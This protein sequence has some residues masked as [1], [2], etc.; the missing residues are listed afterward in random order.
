MQFKTN[1]NHDVLHKIETGDERPT[2]CK[3]RPLLASSE[4]S[5]E[6]HK[7]WLQMQKMGVIE[8]VDPSKLTEW[9]SPLHLARKPQGR[10]WRPCGDFRGLNSKTK[11]DCYPLPIL[12]SFT[13]RLRSA[14]VFS[15]IDLK[16]AFH[17]LPIH[18]DSIDK[19]T[20]LSPWGGAFVFKRLPFGLA[21]GPS[22]YQKFMDKC[23]SGIDNLFTYMDDILVFTETLDQ[24]MSVL[25]ELFKRLEEFGLSLALDKCQFGRKSVDY[26]GYS[27]SSAGI[28]PLS[29]KIQAIVSIPEPT[30]QKELLAFLGGLNYFRSSLQG[31]VKNNKF[32]K[33]A[34]LLQPLYAVATTKLQSKSK[35][36]EVWKHSPHLKSAFQD[37]K[38][39]LINAAELTHP[40]PN[41]P[42]ALVTD[43]SQTSVGA[44]L[45][46][47]STNGVWAPLG[48]F[49]RHLPIDKTKWATYRLE[50]LAVQ[51]ALRHF[52]NEIYGRHLSVWTD[53]KPLEMAFKGQG[54]QL[55]DPVAQRAL[56]EIG[57]FTRDIR[58][59]AGRDNE[60]SDY[61]SRIPLANVTKA[62]IDV[63]KKGTAY[64]D[65]NALEGHKLEAV[66]AKIIAE[67]QGK[68][69]ETEYILKG[70]HSNSVI[71]GPVKFNGVELHSELSQSK[72][73]P[74]LP[75]PLRQFVMQQMHSCGHLGIKENVRKVSSNYYWNTMKTDVTNYVQTCH[76]CQSVKPS[77][78]K[79]PHIGHFEVPEQ[80]FLHCH[81]DLVGP[82]PPSEGHKYILTIKDRSTRFLQALPLKEPTAK[83][84]ADNFLLHWTALFGLP[85]LVTTDQGSAFTSQLWTD[86]QAN[87]GIKVNY[88]PIYYPQANGMIERA[89]QTLKNSMKATLVEMG[90]KYQDK[91]IHY[92]PWALLGM[93]SA[94]NKDLDT[95]SIEMTLG[96][97]VQLPGQILQDPDE[98]FNFDVDQVLKNLQI[99]NNRPAMPTSINVEN[100]PVETLPESVSH[101]YARKH[102][103]R[104]LSPKYIGPFP[105][106]SRPSRSQIVIKVGTNKDGSF[107]T[108]LRH[109]SDIK[110]AYV[111]EG[112]QEA[113]RPKRGRPSKQA[114]VSSPSTSTPP[115]VS[116]PN[117]DLSQPPPSLAANSNLKS[118]SAE[119]QIALITG[120]PP[121]PSFPLKPSSWSA[122]ASD[123]A[124]INQSINTRW[125]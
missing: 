80:R 28:K 115:S 49:S 116:L 102:E 101:V 79:P 51:S 40:D 114:E 13:G 104:G 71:F 108:E 12:R 46:Q 113:V 86:V 76:G 84:I 54:F 59:I 21:N 125:V 20:V 18:P 44:A 26:L 77:R 112:T 60:G 22:S 64:L 93:R 68:C 24:H 23:L 5:K 29:R 78:A 45:V 63:K 72:P 106:I 90:Q 31:L 38:S 92:L 11:P 35:F 99:K 65:V 119:P 19:T 41:K 61:L 73:R 25:E 122:S 48:Y 55:H 66:S 56:I 16:S 42:L 1:A 70:R 100:K 98:E 91:W 27:V 30:T 33:T 83:A 58:H 88:S 52:V 37:A 81:L 118:T 9:A 120:P 34:S 109:I 50:L 87:L 82:L 62:E 110:V 10:G 85:S 121:I 103:A 14:N 96:M 69:P 8:R 53:H 74:I 15:V 57:Q 95:S 2:K 107:R 111:R 89:H 67:E 123:L 97:P 105:V 7:I 6:G 3:V 47:Q 94:Y 4:K 43:A 124:T 32:Y 75:K 17:N 36:Q 117:V 39:L